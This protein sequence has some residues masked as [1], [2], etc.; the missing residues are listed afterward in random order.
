[1]ARR[2][3]ELAVERYRAQDHTTHVIRYA[4]D[5]K[6]VCLS[7]LANTLWFLGLPDDARAARAAALDWATEIGH[8]FSRS[9]ALTFAALLAL[10]MGDELELREYVDELRTSV[11]RR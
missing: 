1:M 7:R 6:V 8:R 10:D 11:T 5:P 4:H 2:Q 9:I 3:F